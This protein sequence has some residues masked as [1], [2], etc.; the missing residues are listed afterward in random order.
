MVAV[1]AEVKHKKRRRARD[2]EE[3]DSAEKMRNLVKAARRPRQHF[4]LDEAPPPSLTKTLGKAINGLGYLLLGPQIRFAAG[5]V[6]L[7]GCLLWLNQND[8]LAWEKLQPTLVAHL[9]LSQDAQ[10][11]LGVEASSA[12]LK[13][14]TLPAVPESITQWVSSF[15]AGV[16][17][18]ILILSVLCRGWV[19]S[20]WMF[21]CALVAW[22]GPQLGV[23]AAGP[24][25]AEV[26]SMAAGVVGALAGAVVRKIS[27]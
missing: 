27:R 1:A 3:E 14:L 9:N 21:P 18:L 16:A 5:A 23:P 13:D 11:T 26:V 10:K 25:S 15:N 24:L 2:E 17:G 22:V 19:I 20:F 6:L 7:L 4:G 12:T 8:R